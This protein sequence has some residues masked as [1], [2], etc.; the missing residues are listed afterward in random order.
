MCIRDRGG[1]V[2]GA[3]HDQ[4]VASGSASLGGTLELQLIDEFKALPGAEFIIIIA[5]QIVGD[6]DEVLFPSLSD[7]WAFKL[8]KEINLSGQDF[9]RLAVVVPIPASVWMLSAGVIGILTRRRNRAV[10]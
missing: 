4:I 6:F 2:P 5:E 7:G 1:L 8:H 10:R 3:Q 9:L